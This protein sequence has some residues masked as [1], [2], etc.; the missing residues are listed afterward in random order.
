MKI[1]YKYI[2]YDFCPTCDKCK[3][4]L[5]DFRVCLILNYLRYYANN[6][7]HPVKTLDVFEL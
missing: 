7:V 6:R 5:N 2:T 4:Y 3:H 1:Y